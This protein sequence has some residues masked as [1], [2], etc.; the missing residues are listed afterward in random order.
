M[1]RALSILATAAALAVSVQIASAA[2]IW[3]PGDG[4]DF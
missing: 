1:I 2:N 3:A 4:S